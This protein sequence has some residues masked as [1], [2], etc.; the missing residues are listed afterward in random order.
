M[1]NNTLR[2]EKKYHNAVAQEFLSQRKYD[3]IWEIPEK[4]FLLKKKYL[5][6]K[7]IVEMGCGPSLLIAKQIKKLN[8]KMKCYIGVD[9]SKNMITLA[10]N[11]FP[12]G[13]FII[14]DITDINLPDSSA[15]TVFSLGALHHTENKNKTLRNWIRILKMKGFLLMREPIYEALRRGTGASPTEEGIDVSKISDYLNKNGMKIKNNI[16]FCSKLFH[17]INR[18]FI[19]ILGSLWLK[20][21]ILWYPV[22]ILDIIT[23][24]TLGKLFSSLRGEACI[25][26]AQK[27]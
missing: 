15:E 17:L 13:R 8:I 25:I 5:Q 23:S 10:K 6:N 7:K 26:I 12:E 1:K 16:F 19:K 27:V 20:N 3:F 22:I 14:D 9:I 21:E 18:V 4:L 2:L 11:S 24:N